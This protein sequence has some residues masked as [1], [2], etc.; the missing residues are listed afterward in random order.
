MY[1]CLTEE[2]VHMLVARLETISAGAPKL[3]VTVLRCK[4]GF[5]ICDA[6]LK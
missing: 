3:V 1:V 2:K 6:V 4:K 5:E